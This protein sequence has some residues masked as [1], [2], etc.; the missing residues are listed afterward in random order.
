MEGEAGGFGDEDVE[1]DE[2][3]VRDFQTSDEG[4]GRMTRCEA[5]GFETSG[6]S[7][8]GFCRSGEVKLTA[9]CS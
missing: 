8:G 7:G 4:G 9:E 5:K 3:E 2:E 1:D 6:T